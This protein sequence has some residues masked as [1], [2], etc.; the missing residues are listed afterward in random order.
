[1][2]LRGLSDLCGSFPLSSVIFCQVSDD[3]FKARSSGESGESMPEVRHGPIVGYDSDRVM[4]D[5]T[6]D[7]MGILPHKGTDAAVRSCLGY[8]VRQCLLSQVK[9]PEKA[10]SQASLEPE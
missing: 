3:N 1:M 10:R 9:S 8:C 2:S 7:K 6:N 4:G 5:S